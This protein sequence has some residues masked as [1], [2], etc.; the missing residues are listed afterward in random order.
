[1]CDFAPEHDVGYVPGGD[2]L[3]AVVVQVGNVCT[4]YSG[5]SPAIKPVYCGVITGIACP[6]LTVTLLAVIVRG[7][8]VTTK[9]P[10][11]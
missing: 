1:M 6:C 10:P 4:P 7:A 9:E 2:E 8:G 11:T 3:V 5:L